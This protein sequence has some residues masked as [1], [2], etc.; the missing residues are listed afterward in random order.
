MRALPHDLVIHSFSLRRH[1]FMSLKLRALGVFLLISCT[2]VI[3]KSPDQP[4]MEAARGDL[5]KAKGEL[6]LATANKG[7]HRSKA[8]GYVNSAIAEVNRGIQFARQNNHATS[9][10]DELFAGATLS[11]DQPH[12]QAA[13]DLLKSAKENLD[14]AT[15]DKGGHRKNAIGYVDSAIDEVKKGIEFAN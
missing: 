10:L 8:I 7:G 6:Q 15:P 5:L 1:T 12:M 9:G 13:L 4:Y 2:V 14:K 11:P 3:A